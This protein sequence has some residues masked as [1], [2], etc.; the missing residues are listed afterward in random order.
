MISPVTDEDSKREGCAQ[1]H[2]QCVEDQHQMLRGWIPNPG[3][4]VQG[5]TPSHVGASGEPGHPGQRRS[6]LLSRQRCYSGG[7]FPGRD[8]DA[9]CSPGGPGHSPYCLRGG[10]RCRRRSLRHYACHLSCSPL[11]GDA[12]H[13]SHPNHPGRASGNCRAGTWRKNHGT[14][15]GAT[16]VPPHLSG[17]HQWLTAPAF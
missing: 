4:P 11:L 13:P 2:P 17:G 12:S 10:V 7:L 14:G 6:C 5:T 8:T 3:V 15:A 9:A 1:S 16:A